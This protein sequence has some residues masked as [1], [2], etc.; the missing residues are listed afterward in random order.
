MKKQ[1]IEKTNNLTKTIYKSCL[2][3]LLL[4]NIQENP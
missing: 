4:V 3:L 2:L 1:K